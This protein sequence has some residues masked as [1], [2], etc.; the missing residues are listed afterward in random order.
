MT[1][2]RDG[3]LSLASYDDLPAYQQKAEIKRLRKEIP[4]AR[5]QAEVA[6]RL[7]ELMEAVPE[8][9][10]SEARA[11]KAKIA[12]VVPK[13]LKKVSAALAK[14]EPKIRGLE[15]FFLNAGDRPKVQLMV[16]NGAHFT[17]EK[18]RKHFVALEENMAS[19]ADRWEPGEK[20]VHMLSY[21]G[22]H[23]QELAESMANLGFKYHALV[24]ADLV[25]AF[26]NYDDLEKYVKE[27]FALKGAAPMLAHLVVPATYA[28]VRCATTDRLENVGLA[29]PLMGKLLSGQRRLAG[30]SVNSLR[31]VGKVALSYPREKTYSKSLADMGLVQVLN[32]GKVMGVATMNESDKNYMMD[33]HAM[34][35]VVGIGHDLIKFSNAMAFT[36]WGDSQKDDLRSKLNK[37]FSRL[38]IE[39]AIHQAPSISFTYDESEQTVGILLAGIGFQPNVARFEI[40]FTA[41]SNDVTLNS[42][43]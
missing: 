30:L 14:E 36:T 24:F 3:K 7:L 17:G 1:V 42:I 40:S 35:T 41:A 2:L 38:V 28:R 20:F 6:H 32:G 26:E 15:L 43:K 13:N 33:F 9:F 27:Y 11:L 25:E 19:E 4:C 31:G 8:N 18:T 29:L 10:V 21:V 37:Y 23:D 22:G 39:E 12:E 5:A 34:Q 16:V